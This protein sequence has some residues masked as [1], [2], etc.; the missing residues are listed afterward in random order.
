MSTLDESLASQRGTR[1]SR[2]WSVLV[3]AFLVMAFG[4]ALRNS[5]SVFY[6]A[7]VEDYGW[8][9]GN[10]AMMFSLSILVYGLFSPVAGSLVD[11]FK[12]QYLVAGGALALGGG[13]ALCGLGTAEWQFYLLFGVLAAVGVSF[14][15]V[16]VLGA[17]VTPWFPHHRG[18]VFG[19]LAAGFGVSLVSASVVQYLI[20]TQGWRNAYFI[21][22]LS[23]AAVMTPLVLLFLRRVPRQPIPASPGALSAPGRRGGP[24]R[25]H[26]LACDGVDPQEGGQGAA[27]L[28]AGARRL[29]PGRCCREDSHRAPGLFLQ[30]CGL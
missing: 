30:G 19:V 18:M 10:T 23:F 22:G 26:G 5:F 7:I 4:F 27:V 12:P 29:L 11:R 13:F 25:G 28:A 15:G 20:S 17:V 9:R 8:T 16:T 2:G 24:G 1:A 6:P 3:V 21:T 14:V